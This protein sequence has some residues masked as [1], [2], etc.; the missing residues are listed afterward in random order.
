L[1]QVLTEREEG[2]AIA[3]NRRADPRVEHNPGQQYRHHTECRNGLGP[4]TGHRE[5]CGTCDGGHGAEYT[6]YSHAPVGVMMHIAHYRHQGTIVD[7]GQCWS[8]NNRAEH[9]G[10]INNRSTQHRDQCQYLGERDQR[11]LP[12]RAVMLVLRVVE[13]FTFGLLRQLSG[14]CGPGVAVA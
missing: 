14:A 9:I 4:L 7:D 1:F 2:S 10:A 8:L 13:T 5:Q 3:I 11:A 12:Y 6:R